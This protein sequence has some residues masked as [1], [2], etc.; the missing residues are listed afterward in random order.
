MIDIGIA[1]FLGYDELRAIK[2]G[3]LT[4]PNIVKIEII[5]NSLLLILLLIKFLYNKKQELK[6]SVEYVRERLKSLPEELKN[7]KTKIKP[8]VHYLQTEK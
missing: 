6:N 4:F 8:P 7:L 5:I 3:G 2:T 1:I